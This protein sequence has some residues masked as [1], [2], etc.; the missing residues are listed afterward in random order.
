MR[1][2]A[3][4]LATFVSLPAGVPAGEVFVPLARAHAHNDYEHERPLLD[5]LSHGFTSVEADIYLVGGELLVAHD[6]EDVVPGR[7]LQNL[8][9]DPL[10]RRVR[11]QPRHGL[12]AAAASSSS[13]WST[14]RTRG[15]ATYTELAPGAARLPPDADDVRARQ[16]APGRGHRRDQRRP[17]AR[18]DGGPAPCGTR[19]TTAA[20][21]DLGG[22]R[23]PRSCR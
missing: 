3:L 22:A 5:A 1:T 13:S 21:P 20:A 11:R 16:G 9:L 18:A 6:P 7:T 15:R 19:S 12:S 14:S 8:Y 23:R 2:A 10:A 4:I 17:P